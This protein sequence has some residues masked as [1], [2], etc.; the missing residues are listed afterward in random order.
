V[1]LEP[2][3]PCPQTAAPRAV[4][5]ACEAVLSAGFSGALATVAKIHGSTPSSPGQKLFLGSDGTC[6]G[7][8]GGGAVERE[9]LKALAKALADTHALPEL[10]EFRLGAELG[11]C[12]GGRVEIF[13][14]P[15]SAAQDVLLIGSGHVGM[16]LCRVLLPLGYRV[17][18]VDSRKDWSARAE[19]LAELQERERM[20]AMQ[21][22][23]SEAAR[24]VAASAWVLV[25][26][27]DHGLD[28]DAIEW[29]LRKGYPFIGGIG[30]RAKAERVKQ[31]LFVKGFAETDLGRIR[32]PL[33]LEI[34]ARAPEEIAVAV[35]AELIA[36]KHRP[37]RE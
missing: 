36:L 9:V 18:M 29:A 20:V 26:T 34:G 14:E 8:I 17:V 28:Q 37:I 12:C 21:G 15:F 3:C 11:M 33:G 4:L 23:P 1:E 5:K 31:R 22:E 24:H 6:V 16:A 32:M 13:I 10:R 35:A 2:L 7:T 27:H 19:S 30:S 25:M